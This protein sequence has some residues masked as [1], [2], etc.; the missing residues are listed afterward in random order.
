M[1]LK[2]ILIIVTVVVVGGLVYF[3]GPFGSNTSSD[4]NESESTSESSTEGEIFY[5]SDSMTEEQKEAYQTALEE[6][7]AE[8]D[9]VGYNTETGD[10]YYDTLITVLADI[11][12]EGYDENVHALA[13]SLDATIGEMS[14]DLIA[15]G[16]YQLT[17]SES[18]TFDEL[19]ALLE[20]VCAEE[21]I[22]SATIVPADSSSIQSEILA[23]TEE[24]S[25][26]E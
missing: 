5:A 6:Y 23:E 14:E 2:L 19:T 20:T 24:S 10:F 17:F 22:Q 4:A 26:D 1:K 16:F 11:E 3:F 18:K 8:T 21:Y 25:I 7:A 13:E 12:Y 15:L 9:G